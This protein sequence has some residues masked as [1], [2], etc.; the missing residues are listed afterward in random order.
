VDVFAMKW[1]M[2]QIYQI[3]IRS[4][5][6]QAGD[7]I[8]PEEKYAI[9]TFG[10][11]VG[12]AT[13]LSKQMTQL[14][15]EKYDRDFWEQTTRAVD[16]PDYM[17]SITGLIIFALY[18]VE[19]ALPIP[20]LKDALTSLATA[21]IDAF[22]VP[23]REYWLETYIPAV[24]KALGFSKMCLGAIMPVMEHIAKF[25]VVFVEAL[26]FQEQTIPVPPVVRDIL[27]FFD[28]VGLTGDLL[29]DMVVTWDYYNG[30]NCIAR[31]DHAN[32]HQKASHGLIHFTAIADLFLTQHNC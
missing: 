15:S 1:L 32:W 23:A 8:T 10:Y 24:R 28:N 13:D 27:V 17:L 3:M 7:G 30:E 19:G 9:E 6:E 26:I 2:L 31:S 29:S 22:D 25:A 20:G 14:F 18:G 4:V 12:K 5:V 21:L 16:I 11:S